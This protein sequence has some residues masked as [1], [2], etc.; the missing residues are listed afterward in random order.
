MPHALLN[1][2]TGECNIYVIANT[3]NAV[4]TQ[5]IHVPGSPTSKPATPYEQGLKRVSDD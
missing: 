2:A 3:E 4:G 5:S 1:S